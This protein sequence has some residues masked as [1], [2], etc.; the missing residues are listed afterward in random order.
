[1]YVRYGR[2]GH[3]PSYVCSTL[4]SDYGLPLCQMTAAVEV[5]AWVAEQ[6]LEALW[7]AV[8]EA[9][10][11]S[12][13]EVEERRRQAVRHREQ[14]IERSRYEAERAARQYHACEPENRLV[15]R[16]LER[17]WDEALQAVRQLEVELDRF[18]RAQ[19]RLLGEAKRE[20][21]R[22]LAVEV[23]TLWHAPTIT[24]ADRRQVARLLIDRVVLTVA[25]GDDRVAVRVEWAGGEVRERTIHRDV[26]GYKHQ[27]D[28]PILSARLAELHGRGE[29]PKEIAAA[30]EGDGFRPPKRASRF[31]AGMVRRLLHDFGLRPRVPR[32]AAETDALSP[33]EGWLHELVGVLGLSPHTL[34]RW[35]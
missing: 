28:W 31:T 5:E 4:R 15:A 19:P 6:V 33:G 25:T 22:R 23:P 12:A 13:A 8:L 16:T 21:I 10:M 11:G 2:P 26:Q 34:Q 24:A 27:Q 35:R 14:R 1:M 18:T 9:S 20:Q 29:T 17:Q 3:R 32:S 30:L 7:P